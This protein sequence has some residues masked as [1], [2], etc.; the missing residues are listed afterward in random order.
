MGMS[1]CYKPSRVSCDK[2]VKQA[3]TRLFTPVLSRGG[4]SDMYA[5]VV[6]FRSWENCKSHH[7]P[8]QK[9]GVV[10]VQCVKSLKIFFF[11]IGPYLG[12]TSPYLLFRLSLDSS[13]VT[14]GKGR[15][16]EVCGEEC[17]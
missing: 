15:G 9:R 6:Q 7:A 11:N 16:G 5:Y 17:Q 1:R 12:D 8:A 2:Q 4:S 3:A 13:K 10:L 14:H